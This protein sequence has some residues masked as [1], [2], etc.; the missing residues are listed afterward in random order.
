MNLSI[1]HGFNL[2]KLLSLLNFKFFHFWPG[3]FSIWL[4][5]PPDKTL[6][7]F[8]SLLAS[9]YDKMYQA[10][11]VHFLSRRRISHFSK[12]PIFFPQWEVIFADHSL[13]IG[14]LTAPVLVSVSNPLH[15]TKLHIYISV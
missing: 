15:C 13:S 8:E 3:G 2:F 6:K 1:V 5:S 10:H 7:V 14:L 12:K 11:L 9:W 4:L